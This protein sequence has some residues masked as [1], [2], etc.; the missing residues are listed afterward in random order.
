MACHTQREG[1]DA[2]KDL[3]L[4][5]ATIYLALWIHTEEWNKLLYLIFKKYATSYLCPFLWNNC[6]QLWSIIMLIIGP[7]AC[8]IILK[9][10]FSQLYNSRPWTSWIVV[11]GFQSCG[12]QVDLNS[13]SALSLKQRIDVPPST[14]PESPVSIKLRDVKRGCALSFAIFSSNWAVS[15]IAFKFPYWYS[16]T[17]KEW[18]HIFLWIQSPSQLFNSSQVLSLIKYLQGQTQRGNLRVLF[19]LTSCTHSEFLTKLPFG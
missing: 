18:S 16:Y 4:W 1:D 3:T 5:A 7:R 15:E 10:L 14:T 9:V 2:N 17:R 12:F 6:C 8:K 11:N 13:S 19:L